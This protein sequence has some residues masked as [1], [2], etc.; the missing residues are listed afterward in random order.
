MTKKIFTKSLALYLRKHGFKIVGMDINK[1]FPQYDVW[2]FED[3]PE[4]DKAILD[5][6]RQKQ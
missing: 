5:Y 4:L 1:R 2:I 3:N 6:K